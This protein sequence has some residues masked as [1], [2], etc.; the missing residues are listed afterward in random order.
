MTIPNDWT[1]KYEQ[2]KDL[3]ISPVNFRELF[4]KKAVQDKNLF[5]LPMGEVNFPT[6]EILV[7]DPL[8]YL[9][10]G[11]KPY[12]QKVP[13]GRYNIETL[14]AELEEDHYRYVA[15][16]IA[17]NQNRPIVYR[18][19]L[20]GDEDLTGLN[21]NSIFG[22]AVD[23]GLATIVDIKT[24]EAFCDFEEAWYKNNPGGN[25]YDDFFADEFSRSYEIN[26]A[27]QRSGGDWINFKLP[28]TDLSIPMIQS[29]FG[30]G[31]YPVYFGYDENDLVCEVV[32]EYIF[33]G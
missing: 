11:E 9:H 14:V 7:R 33:A 29:G 6:G 19:A 17:F 3:L 5:V 20:K 24:L 28:G 21:E 4:A 8:V 27:Y 10:R 30:D 22:F 23:A 31:L 12:F 1:E 26:P 32:I 16:R 15:T 18:Q 13:T 25:I 2:V